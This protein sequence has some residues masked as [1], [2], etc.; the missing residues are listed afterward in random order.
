[1]LHRNGKQ[2]EPF[3][4]RLRQQSFARLPGFCAASVA[5]CLFPLNATG[6]SADIP[7]TGN[8]TVSGDS[9]T[10]QVLNDGRLDATPNLRVLDSRR[11]GGFPAQILVTSRRPAVA[12]TPGFQ[13]TF[14]PPA[15]FAISPPGTG[16]DIDWRVWHE[17]TSVTDGINFTRRRGFR[18]RTL[19][20]TGFSVTQVAGHLRARRNNG[21]YPEGSYRA[22]GI[23]RCE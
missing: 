16:N 2:T 4:P 1:M 5:L 12:T 7:F 15:N 11:F 9:C 8:V 18:S 6:Q 10:I 13:I 21:I 23:Y 14:D 17:G 20:A 19:P 3:G 22:I